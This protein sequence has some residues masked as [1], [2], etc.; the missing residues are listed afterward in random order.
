M[1]ILVNG[2]QVRGFEGTKDS[3]QLEF[4]APVSYGTIFRLS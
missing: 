4:D 2:L 3:L 1:L